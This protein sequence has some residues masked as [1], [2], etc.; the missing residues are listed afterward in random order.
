[1]CRRRGR[2]P[3]GIPPPVGV[4]LG[5]Q[6]LLS[7]QVWGSGHWVR[8]RF[9]S[10]PWMVCPCYAGA[11]SHRWDLEALPSGQDP[12][13][14]LLKLSPPPTPFGDCLCNFFPVGPFPQR[15]DTC[16]EL[17]LG[18]CQCPWDRDIGKGHLQIWGFQRENAG[19]KGQIQIS[20]N[21][22][23]CTVLFFTTSSSLFP[24]AKPKDQHSLLTFYYFIY[25]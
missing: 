17:L 15:T 2:R 22:L 21:Y 7:C 5:I 12:S 18:F 20:I 3:G 11:P 19:E 16:Q 23:S 14:F 6:W 13:P 25:F 10:F 8:V 1:M 24:E 4:L 9:D